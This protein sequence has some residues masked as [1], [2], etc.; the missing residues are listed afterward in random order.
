M[1]SEST[2]VLGPKG[3]VLYQLSRFDPSVH[4]LNDSF[5]AWPTLG[6]R[7]SGCQ[8][9]IPGPNLQEKRRPKPPPS[10]LA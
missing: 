2:G 9:S 6:F 10:H 1:L 8:T 3:E 4:A 5:A 7:L